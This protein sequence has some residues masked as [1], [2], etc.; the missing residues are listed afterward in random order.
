MFALLVLLGFGAAGE[1]FWLQRE[2]QA[3]GPAPALSRIEVIPG[4]SVRAVL[5]ELQRLGDVR[6]SRAVIW[7]LRLRG[8]HTRMHSGVYEIPPHTSPKQINGNF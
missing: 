7:Y 3:A 4:A 6:N 2:F 8:A 5:S 1:Y